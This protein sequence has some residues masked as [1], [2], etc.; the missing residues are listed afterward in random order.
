MPIYPSIHQ[1][2]NRFKRKMKTKGTFG[3]E[4]E[5]K[6]EIVRKKEEDKDDGEQTPPLIGTHALS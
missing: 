2:L 1:Q 4:T 5:P 6:R 3:A